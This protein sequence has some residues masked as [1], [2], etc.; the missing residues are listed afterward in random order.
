MEAIEVLL[1]V[2]QLNSLNQKKIHFIISKIFGILA[3]FA[4][5]DMTSTDNTAVNS[6]DHGNHSTLSTAEPKRKVSILTDPP[7]AYD[8]HA[9][10]GPRR[11]ISQVR[12]QAII[13]P[14]L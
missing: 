2:G 3:L 9:F 14:N 12:I 4:A 13:K 1:P 5:F 6:N 8:N 7:S 10:D 11:K